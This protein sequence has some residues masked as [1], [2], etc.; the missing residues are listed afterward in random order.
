MKPTCL[1]ELHILYTVLDGYVSLDKRWNLL[2]ILD[3]I[4][5]YS[6]VKSETIVDTDGQ[7]TFRDRDFHVTMLQCR[8]R[9]RF[10]VEKP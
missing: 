2:N 4:L 9:K 3:Q 1:I 6:R 7:F 8:P 5:R 10:L